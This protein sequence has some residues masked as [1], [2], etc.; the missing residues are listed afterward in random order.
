MNYTIN[1]IQQIG[2]GV[3]DAKAVFNWYRKHYGFDILVFED[4]AEASLMTQFT[5][6]KIETRK[7]LLAMNILGGG[8]LE[9]WQFKNRIPQMGIKPMELGDLGINLIKLRTSRPELKSFTKDV[10]GNWIQHVFDGYQFHST[11]H[12]SGGVLGAM[13]GVSNMKASL[14]FYAE[15]FGFD[16][17][18]SDE[19]GVFEDFEH[20]AG[21][22]SRF[23]RVLLKRSSLETGGF[24]KLL[25]PMQLELLQVMGRNPNK[26]FESRMWGD[27]GYI[28]ICFDVWGMDALKERAGILG[29]GFA[30]DSADSFDMGE[31][32]GRF[33][34]IEDPDGTLIELVETHKVPICK[35][36]GLYINLKK[37]NP[38]KPL[39]NFM[40]KALKLH[41]IK[42]DL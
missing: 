28:H 16:V 9:I 7:A 20:F 38:M 25:G 34:Y 3:N 8:G 30:V 6:G 18:V 10:F 42:K 29:H 12:Y 33:A 39:P 13:V 23:R 26:I 21:G 5:G 41:R 17:V 2:I 37:R 31:A 35:P 24:G 11:K 40:V 32:A 27:L 36:L 19:T 15:I 4:E 22:K 1:G 14:A